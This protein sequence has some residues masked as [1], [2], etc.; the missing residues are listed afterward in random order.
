[1]PHL[2]AVRTSPKRTGSIP[3]LESGERHPRSAIERA[4]HG[5]PGCGNVTRHRIRALR[6]ARTGPSGSRQ[7]DR[8]SLDLLRGGSRGRSRTALTVMQES[9][10]LKV[11][12]PVEAAEVDVDEIAHHPNGR[13]SPGTRRNRLS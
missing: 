2:E 12:V 9:A 8:T 10:T 5:V 3:E 6:A 1:M 7:T 4:I 11:E 13:P